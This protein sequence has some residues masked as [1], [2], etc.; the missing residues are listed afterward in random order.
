MESNRTEQNRAEHRIRTKGRDRTR[1]CQ[2][3]LSNIK[4][5]HSIYH[6]RKTDTFASDKFDKS[7]IYFLNDF[8]MEN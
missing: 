5:C 1:F 2:I 3:A 7:V 4:L 8:G 6:V